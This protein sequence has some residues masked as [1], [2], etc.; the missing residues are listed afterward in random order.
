MALDMDQLI[1]RRRLKRRLLLWR[2]AAI[3]LAVA[4]VA[5]VAGR[6]GLEGIDRDHVAL[7][8]VEGVILDDSKR[9]AALDRVASDPNAKALILRINSP[10]GSVVG[11]ESLYLALRR[12]AAHKPVV[13]VM[14]DVAASAGYMI[15]LGADRIVARA[16]T[17]TGSIGVVMWST[18]VTGLLEKL[19]VK[20]ETVKSAPLKAQPNPMEPF[21]PEAR[22]AI[23][24]V[25]DDFFGL[26]LDMVAERRAM[27]RE[28]ALALADGRVFTGR[29]ALTAGLVD[30]IGGDVEARDWL[31]DRLGLP[32]L[33]PVIPVRIADDEAPWNRIFDDLVGK[34][35]FS[36]RLRLDGLVS[37][38]HPD[39][40]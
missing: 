19:G 23:R 8:A 35:V 40:R 26:F 36:E 24:S 30:A 6:F 10:G 17:V 5:A 7:L 25:V 20:A 31:A 33:P 12:V 15:A 16:G 37:L 4:A 22:V 2:V 28:R 32:E 34:A 1:D 21:T 18:D 39:L 3:A 14:G 29:Q 38:W 9:E 27:A 13:A 11:G